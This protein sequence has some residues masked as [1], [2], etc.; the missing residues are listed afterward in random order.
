[1]NDHDELCH[2]MNSNSASVKAV[3]LNSNEY[4]RILIFYVH[5]K[6]GER[7][8]LCEKKTT[9]LLRYFLLVCAFVSRHTPNFR[10]EKLR[11]L[12]NADKVP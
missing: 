10:V 2:S 9:F 5:E 4:L 12:F 7:E 6:G 8:K 1:M 11:R 3:C